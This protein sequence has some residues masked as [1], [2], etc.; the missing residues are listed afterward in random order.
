MVK[1]QKLSDFC[2]HLAWAIVGQECS[3]KSNPFNKLAY[4]CDKHVNADD[5]WDDDL[6][7]IGW[8]ATIACKVAKPITRL[9]NW[10]DPV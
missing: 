9:S 3:C 7:T 4:W 10:L 6:N 8:K 5:Q 2:Q 1:N